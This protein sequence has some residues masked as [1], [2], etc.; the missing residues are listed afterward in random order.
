MTRA[1]LRNLCA[2]CVICN[3]NDI[4][5]MMSDGVADNLDPEVLGKPS[6]SGVAWADMDDV[7][8]HNEKTRWRCDFLAATMRASKFQ[9]SEFVR[10]V[11][12]FCSD[13]TRPSRRF[14]EE[15]PGRALPDDYDL[16]AGKMDHT[17]LV[18]FRATRIQ[19]SRLFCLGCF[20]AH[21]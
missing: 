18:A 13:T 5:L 11:V 16:Y 3:E 6:S 10:I 12:Q 7:A 15:N 1:D 8:R 19:V 4:I 2:R 20:E 17:T 21:T 14:M 9:L